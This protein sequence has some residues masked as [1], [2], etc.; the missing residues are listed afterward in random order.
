MW[1]MG[2]LSRCDIFRR[3]MAEYQKRLIYPNAHV[4][5]T[6]TPAE[7]AQIRYLSY[8]PRSKSS[9]GISSLPAYRTESKGFPSSFAKHGIDFRS[10]YDTL[11]RRGARGPKCNSGGN[12][13]NLNGMHNNDDSIPNYT[14]IAHHI[15]LRQRATG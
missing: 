4:R 8:Q 11:R 2:G 13:K 6:A 7:F 14:N 1:E 10:L 9:R 5:E 15:P 12:I 3:P